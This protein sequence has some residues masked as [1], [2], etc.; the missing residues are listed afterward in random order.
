MRMRRQAFLVV[1]VLFPFPCHNFFLFFWSIHNI[2]CR[3]DSLQARRSLHCTKN[4]S[5]SFHQSSPKLT[6]TYEN[7]MGASGC[8]CFKP[9]SLIFFWLIH[10][11]Y[12][13]RLPDARSHHTSNRGTS[14]HQK[15]L[16]EFWEMGIFGCLLWVFSSLSYVYVF[17]FQHNIMYSRCLPNTEDPASHEQKRHFCKACQ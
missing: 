16:D 15:C 7:V 8:W 12:S 9:F 5:A 11:I 1:L 14:S 6:L 17:S 13:T 3:T 10:I 2:M 4:L